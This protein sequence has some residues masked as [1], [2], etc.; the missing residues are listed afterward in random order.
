MVIYVLSESDCEEKGETMSNMVEF[1]NVKVGN[2][3]RINYGDF[4]NFVTG[5]VVDVVNTK[6]DKRLFINT[7]KSVV[8]VCY[9]YGNEKV[10]VLG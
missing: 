3:V 1:K 6:Q 8:E 9:L 7:G 5:M 2:K 10:E 4:D